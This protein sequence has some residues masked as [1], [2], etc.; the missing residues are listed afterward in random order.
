WD[1][2]MDSAKND[3]DLGT[4]W[5]PEDRAW[6]WYN[7]TV[8][9]QAFALR[10]LPELQPSDPRRDGLVQWLFLNKQ[11]NHWK[12][13]RATAE[14]LYA[15]A[16]YLEK[17]KLLRVREAVKVTA[18]PKTVDFVFEPDR[19]TG[20]ENRVVIPGSAIDPAKSST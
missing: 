10:T 7:D 16:H 14:V 8:E 13:T 2:V 18:F 12:S 11:L 17:E 9:T 3:R 5:A 20:K 15:L 4:Y 19:Y 1:S 6:L